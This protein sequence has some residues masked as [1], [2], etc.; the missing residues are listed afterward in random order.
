MKTT[1][2]LVYYIIGILIFIGLK[3][4]YTYANNNHVLLLT[5]PTD[6][7]ISLITY[8]FS[9]YSESTGFYHEKLNM[10]IDKSCSGFNFWMLSFI[11]FFFSSLKFVKHHYLKFL[12]LLLSL[13]LAYIV[14]LFVNTSRILVSLFIEHSTQFKHAWLHQAEGVFIYLSFLIIFYMLL[15]YIQTKSIKNHEKLT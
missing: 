13:L 12:T 2:N 8:S 1:N 15:N 14:T 6:K 4:T 9:T 7:M 11:L 5:S 3:F 10:V